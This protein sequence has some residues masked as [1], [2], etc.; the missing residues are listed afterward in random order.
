VRQERERRCAEIAK[1]YRARAKT[2]ANL[3][4]LEKGY[5]YSCPRVVEDF[6]AL[7]EKAPAEESPA[8]VDT[9]ARPEAPAKPR[10]ETPAVLPVADEKI[11]ENCYLLFSIKNYLEAL[12]ACSEPAA[13]GDVK[14]QYQLGV[15]YRVLG[16]YQEAFKWTRLAVAQG[17][18]EAQYHLG[19]LYYNG[20]GVS[21]DYGEALGWFKRAGEQGVSAALYSVGRMYYQGKGTRRDYRLAAQWF[22]RAARLGEAE[23]WLSLGRM[24]ANGEGV[25]V[26]GES[27]KKYFLRAASLGNAEAQYSLGAMY[28]EGRLTPVDQV[29]AYVWFS[30]AAS[31]G[32]RQSEAS[33]DR[34]GQALSA[35]QLAQ[36]RQRL[37]ER[38]APGKR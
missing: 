37:G 12:P 13:L 26:D 2:P 21:Q 8:T 10:D 33:R 17:L 36:A 34:L 30:L 29:E 25:T 16:S 20:Q 35:G 38:S 31:N 3:S 6:A 5:R 19:Q 28:A 11:R 1:T 27:A 32:H 18:A 23:A 7:V 22:E 4:K 24:S 14:A 9:A 15:M